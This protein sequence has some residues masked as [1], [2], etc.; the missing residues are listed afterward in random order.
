M[1]EFRYYIFCCR[2]P[3]CLALWLWCLIHMI[4][5][6]PIIPCL[7]ARPP[8]QVRSPKIR[9][10]FHYRSTIDQPSKLPAS[11]LSADWSSPGVSHDQNDFHI[12]RAAVLDCFSV[13]QTTARASFTF[14]WHTT[15]STYPVHWVPIIVS[16]W[17][18][19]RFVSEWINWSDLKDIT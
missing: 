15:F 17:W 6:C 8:D 1:M 2:E 14:S 11:S 9:S 10:S 16:Y 7:H 12:E 19:G 4:Y 3:S 5:H 18:R 13:I